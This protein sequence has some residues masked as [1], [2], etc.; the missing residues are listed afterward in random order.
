LNCKHVRK[1]EGVGIRYFRYHFDSIF[2]VFFDGFFSKYEKS[3][4]LASNISLKIESTEKVL[5][6]TSKRRP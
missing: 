3:V 2:S 1:K 5:Y 6:T 4:F